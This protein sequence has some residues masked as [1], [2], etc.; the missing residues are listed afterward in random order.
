[1]KKLFPL[2][3]VGGLGYLI[4]K[5]SSGFN[6]ITKVKNGLKWIFLPHENSDF[7]PLDLQE[8]GFW[9]IAP[10]E[11]TYEKPDLT[12]PLNNLPPADVSSY[13]DYRLI[14]DKSTDLPPFQF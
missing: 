10:F 7:H 13:F 6:P 9:S 5:K 4:I 8:K 2:L 14:P 3:I 12:R 11:K 1:M